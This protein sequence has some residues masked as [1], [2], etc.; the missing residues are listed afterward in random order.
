[1]S[2]ILNRF[3]NFKSKAL[4]TI[5]DLD[6]NIVKNALNKAQEAVDKIQNDE[7]FKE[8]IKTSKIALKQANEDNKQKQE[9]LKKASD[10]IKFSIKN[11]LPV[12]EKTT[13]SASSK[14]N[15]IPD[16]KRYAPSINQGILSL[17][18]SSAG[19]R[20]T[21]GIV[22]FETQK[23]QI[24]YKDSKLVSIKETCNDIY[25]KF[26]CD[27]QSI[28]IGIQCD[29][30][31]ERYAL[32]DSVLCNVKELSPAM[33]SLKK[34]KENIKTLK[35]HLV[36]Y[37]RL[38]VDRILVEQPVSYRGGISKIPYSAD[39]AG[40]CFIFDDRIIFYDD[41]IA[42]E[43]LFNKLLT[44]ELD[45]FQLRGSRAFF[46]GSHTSRMLQEVKNTVAI[47]YLDD[48]D[49]KQTVKLQIHGALSIP[50]EAIKAAEFLN[51]L[52][53]YSDQFPEEKPVDSSVGSDNNDL[54]LLK[55]LKDLK[56]AGIITESE[57]DL[58]KAE[59]LDR[60]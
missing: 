58:K 16:E 37:V 38:N 24:D 46:A 6:N 35:K 26:L 7:K 25:F 33:V 11:N 36:E 45:Y 48:N 55:K 32:I 34:E 23:L 5:D 19:I 50:G 10:F 27:E 41:S 39:K 4:E 13:D 60:L 18:V 47:T 1:M 3:N 44:A 40:I 54:N 12:S 59:I 9:K 52:L 20:G 28:S 53:S 31:L 21:S 49:K 2:N 29:N 17:Y 51:H 14:L 30:F 22:G 57:F 15:V 42:L 56:E 8:A 43:I